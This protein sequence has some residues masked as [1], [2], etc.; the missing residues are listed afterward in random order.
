[1]SS[2]RPLATSTRSPPT[3]RFSPSRRGTLCRPGPEPAPH[4]HG[5]DGCT[6]AVAA[7]MPGFRRRG[8]AAAPA[9]FLAPIRPLAGEVTPGFPGSR[10]AWNLPTFAGP[11]SRSSTPWPWPSPPR[12]QFEQARRPA[13]GHSPRHV[14]EAGQVPRE[15][16][17]SRFW[18]ASGVFLAPRRPQSDAR[19]HSAIVRT[20]TGRSSGRRRAGPWWLPC[21]LATRAGVKQAHRRRPVPGP[22]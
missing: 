12:F 6:A 8:D 10:R 3:P 22:W 2:T 5:C 7:S 21:R 1:M 4:H 19:A 13:P 9:P 20:L 15:T 14:P 11:R 18:P 17:S 16:P